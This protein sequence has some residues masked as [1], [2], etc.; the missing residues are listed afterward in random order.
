MSQEEIQIIA[1]R[2]AA[3]TSI[4]QKEVLTAEEAARYMGVSVSYLYQLTAQRSIP[5]SKP[6]GKKI[7]FRRAELEA[8]L[9]QNPVSTMEQINEKAQS[10]CSGAG[11]AK[12]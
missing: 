4:S 2:I 12:R 9:M 6:V 3:Q 10:V 5:H 1:D 11:R 7:Y 8:W